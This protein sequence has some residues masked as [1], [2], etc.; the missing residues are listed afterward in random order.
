MADEG[1]VG[2][3]LNL[4]NQQKEIYSRMLEISVEKKDV[5]I[6][7]D[8]QKL[9]AMTAEENS[10]VGKSQRLE[11]ARM[12]LI[13]DIA[14]VLGKQQKDV[15]LGYLADALRGQP[16]A[17][18]IEDVASSVRETLVQLKQYNELNRSLMQNALEY[19]DFS[20]NVI[21]GAASNE[22][23]YASPYGDDGGTPSSRSIFDA[24]R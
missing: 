15:T 5:L 10:L 14:Q 7:N 8:I 20:I 1:M 13:A 21:R 11:R 24:H 17:K 6:G 3:M 18:E 12:G 16:E 19:I 2:E 22:V 23:H 4:L 9:K